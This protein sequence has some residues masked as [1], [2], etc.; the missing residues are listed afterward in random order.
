MYTCAWLF[1]W[2]KFLDIILWTL[3][4]TPVINLKLFQKKK[5]NN[6]VSSSMYV[7]MHTY[8]LGVFLRFSNHFFQWMYLMSFS[9]TSERIKWVMLHL[10]HKK[11]SEILEEWW[12]KEYINKRL[13][14]T[15]TWS[16]I[17]TTLCFFS[18]YT[19]LYIYLH[20]DACLFFFTWI[21]YI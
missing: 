15:I 2:H 21:A 17:Y 9:S 20:L 18:L 16:R 4:V 7:C 19:T 5:L 11:Y 6:I 3:Y 14:F 13:L 12:M 10:A 8:T 1:P